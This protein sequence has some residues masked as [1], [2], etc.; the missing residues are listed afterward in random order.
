MAITGG[1]HLEVYV[2]VCIA[3]Y[4]E[5]VGVGAPI[6][7]VVIA[8]VAYAPPV[9]ICGFEGGLGP[10]KG[11]TET[12]VLT[13]HGEIGEGSHGSRRAAGGIAEGRAKG[14]RERM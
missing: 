1:V 14:R 9:E 5:T 7:Q 8:H 11:G 2:G 3:S 13:V 4:T 10:V 6:G 12:V